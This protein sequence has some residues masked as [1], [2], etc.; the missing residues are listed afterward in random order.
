MSKLKAHGTFLIIF[1]LLLTYLFSVPKYLV[2]YVYRLCVFLSVMEI[3]VQ[4]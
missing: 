3:H 2:A 1:I 4:H